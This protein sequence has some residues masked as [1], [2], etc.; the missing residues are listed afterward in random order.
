MINEQ[1]KK[2]IC[3][4]CEAIFRNNK[5]SE[6]IDVY[7]KAIDVEIENEQLD[8]LNKSLAYVINRIFGSGTHLMEEDFEIITDYFFRIENFV[9]KILYIVDEQA[10][11]E[12]KADKK[13]T[14][15][16]ILDKL[17]LL[18]DAKAP[19]GWIDFTAKEEYRN[20]SNCIYNILKAYELR[21]ETTHEARER[22]WVGLFTNIENIIVSELYIC[23]KFRRHIEGLYDINEVSQIID[24]RVHCEN[25]VNA[26]ETRIKNGF[27][28]VPV[29]WQ[30]EKTTTNADVTEDGFSMENMA[31]IFHKRKHI[32]LRGDAGCGKTTSVEYLE[33]QDA[34]RYLEDDA[35]PI[36]ILLRL[37]EYTERDFDIERIICEKLNVSLND[38]L[39]LLEKKALHIYLDGVNEIIISSEQKSDVVT[40]IEQFMRKN[41]E[42][43]IVVTDRKNVE[44]ELEVSMPTLFLKQ[45]QKEDIERYVNCKVGRVDAH[46]QIVDAVVAY[47]DKAS[48]DGIYATPLILD[49]L[50]DS[51][52][53]ETGLPENSAEFYLGYIR[54]LLK[55]EYMEKKD[56]SAAPGRLDILLLYLAFHMPEEGFSMV[57]ILLNFSQCRK[58]LGIEKID[59]VHC[60]KLAV[61]L[62]IL[63]NTGELYRFANTNYAECLFAEALEKGLD[64]LDG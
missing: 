7:E 28:F 12:L 38:A 36:P 3:K 52:Q 63:E 5:V 49:F 42:V 15:G 20:R 18:D 29:I 54:H 40:K 59:N 53:K 27:E 22:T 26:Y 39:I 41:K 19:S 11:E 2:E 30:K 48:F 13:L 14:C 61:Q 50:I 33:Y 16:F 6:M 60:M 34:K 62:G 46:T 1:A 21:N 58:V 55:R 35:N 24:A 56:L 51:A 17:G 37:A 8:G 23:W 64:E 43:Q 31:Q 25:I 57:Q 47:L 9:K 32:M 4:Q 45:M 44:I 10:Y